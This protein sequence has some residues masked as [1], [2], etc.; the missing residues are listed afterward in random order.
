ML[1]LIS[2]FDLRERVQGAVAVNIHKHHAR[3]SSEDEQVDIMLRPACNG[4]ETLIH[5]Q[6]E[7]QQA[8]PDATETQAK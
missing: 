3:S 6:S 2:N 4:R 5:E 1:G 8:F 7:Y